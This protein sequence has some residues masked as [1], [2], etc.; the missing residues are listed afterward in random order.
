MIK[1]WPYRL[2]GTGLLR[3]GQRA[4][5]SAAMLHPV[6]DPKDL[7]QFGVLE[8]LLAQ[9]QAGHD[10]ALTDLFDWHKRRLEVVQGAV[11]GGLASRQDVGVLDEQ[12]LAAMRSIPGFQF[13][14]N[15]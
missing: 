6:V 15:R 11:D 13:F 12:V 1:S 10:A 14:T 2:L 9:V 3:S 4:S 8:R 5:A 7:V